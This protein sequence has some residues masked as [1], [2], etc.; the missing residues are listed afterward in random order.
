MNLNES[1]PIVGNILG[2]KQVTNRTEKVKAEL[3]VL[4][5]RWAKSGLVDMYIQMNR[6]NNFL[7]VL[8]F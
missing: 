5:L 1:K 8:P 7:L 3:S 2:V 4:T 6:D